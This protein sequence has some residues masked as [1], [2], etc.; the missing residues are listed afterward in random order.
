MQ[1]VIVA[2]E[3]TLVAARSNA[4]LTRDI[5]GVG[6]LERT[7]VTAQRAGAS[8]VLLVWP[9]SLPLSLAAGTL[10][11]PLVKKKDNV[12]LVQVERFDPNAHSSWMNLQGRLEDQFIWLPWN[13]VT[14]PRA[15]ARLPELKQSSP[16]W[17]GPTWA[18]KTEVVSAVSPGPRIGPAPEGIAVTSDNTADAAE[19]ILVARSGKASDGIHTSFNRRLCRVIVRWLSHTRVTPNAVTLGGVVLAIFSAMAF[20]RG[21]Y[22]SYVAGAL[23]FYIAGLFDEMDGMLAR[24][25][26]SDS[27]F[28]TWFEGFADG[29][30]YVLLFGSVT[31]GLYRQHGPRELWVGAA[32]LVGTILS[33]VVISLQRKRAAS[34]DRPHEYLGNFYRKLEDDSSNWISRMVRQVHAFQR[35][36]VMIIY[37]VIFTVLGGLP[38]VFYLATLGSHVT[39]IVVLYF[40]RRFFQ[41]AIP[42]FRKIQSSQEA[43]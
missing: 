13:W 36:G 10:Q 15:L 38:V 14:Y 42:R 22:W 23:L 21:N 2:P 12:R 28:G 25:K 5:C 9:Q 32:L 1:I 6:L 11:S 31:I 29:I 20:A 27:P 4:E 37:I 30:S 40:N 16:D 3:A 33:L 24:I 7:L 35:R 39:W 18:S 43:S 19:R 26:F 41:P 17:D 8:E 34:A